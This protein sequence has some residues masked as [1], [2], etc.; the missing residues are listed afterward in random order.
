MTDAPVI[1]VA[2]VVLRD[3]D[4][5]VLNVRKRGTTMFMLP[6]GKPEPGET[7]SQTAVREIAEEL[8]I[9]LDEA[10]LILLG[11]FEAPAANEPGHVVRSTVF[12]HPGRHDPSIA[13]EIVE[14]RWSTLDELEADPTIAP[15]TSQR[16]APLLRPTPNSRK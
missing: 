15:L 3:D 1:T 9:V 10:E 16:V 7:P 5:R 2:A 4:G 13:A 8:G 11:E 6:G 12:T 14:L